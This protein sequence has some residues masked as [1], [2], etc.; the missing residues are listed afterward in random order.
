MQNINEHE[1]L[2]TSYA[3]PLEH[4]K[5]KEEILL[6]Q[7][8]N[9]IKP[10]KVTD[11]HILCLLNSFDND[12][13][14]SI[15]SITKYID[16]F[17][18]YSNKDGTINKEDIKKEIDANIAQWHKTDKNGFPTLI[19]RTS[20]YIAKNHETKNMIKLMLFHI[21]E[22][23]KQMDNFK[24]NQVSI[25][26]NREGFEKQ[27]H[28]SQD[29]A[30]SLKDI[31]Q[32]FMDNTADFYSRV[33]ITNIN[34]FYRGIFAIAKTFMKKK[35]IDK[36]KL[37]GDNEDLLEYFFKDSLPKDLGGFEREDDYMLDLE[38]ENKDVENIQKI[39][40]RNI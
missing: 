31:R 40:N 26:W 15:E 36:V 5:L 27:I 7:S 9:E 25:I 1:S 21:E 17:H 16:F 32:C 37:V 13:P 3:Y 33:Y 14:K 22:A 38:K 23:F 4:Q 39:K 10:F 11:R 19:V 30:D 20:N 28:F 8:R 2:N 24:L 12:I 34:W 35:I 6:R 29:F 18:E